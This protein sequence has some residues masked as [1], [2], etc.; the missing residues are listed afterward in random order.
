MKARNGSNAPAAGLVR[1]VT[2]SAAK[3]EP[4]C[5]RA[6]RGAKFWAGLPPVE[7][8]RE[9]W[10]KM[11][12]S[13]EDKYRISKLGWTRQ[14]EDCSQRPLL[15][16][17]M[18]L[19]PTLGRHRWFS[20][21]DSLAL[22]QCHHLAQVRASDRVHFHMQTQP[23]PAAFQGCPETQS[24]SHHAMASSQVPTMYTTF[25]SVDHQ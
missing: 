21:D 5:Y 4:W 20:I 6:A 15:V 2:S 23:Q 17:W 16:D 11:V 7:T 1:T 22:Y 24:R 14:W 8:S 12:D 9:G 10:G 19:Y 25:R 18:G 3:V 13:F